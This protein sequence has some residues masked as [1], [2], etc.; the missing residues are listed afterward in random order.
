MRYVYGIK[1]SSNLNQNQNY[2]RNYVNRF[3]K[4]SFKNFVFYKFLLLFYKIIK[5]STPKFL[6]QLFI[7]SHSTRNVEI[8]IPRI[9]NSIFERSFLV[10]I[11][12]DWNHLPSHLRKF[13]FSHIVY[14][15]RLTEYV[16]QNWLISFV[17]LLV[18]HCW[19]GSILIFGSYNYFYVTNLRHYSD[20]ILELRSYYKCLITCMNIKEK[21]YK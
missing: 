14:R 4:C 16:N 6:V 17:S 1:L 11:A 12:R 19:F 18:F 13:S 20:K 15:K 2:Q 10:R 9:N 8:F 3:L 5:N 7:F 21:V